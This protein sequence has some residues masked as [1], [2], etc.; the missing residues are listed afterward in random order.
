[1]PEQDGYKEFLPTSPLEGPPL[2]R[3]MGVAWPWQ[4]GAEGPMRRLQ[5][6]KFNPLLM[7]QE[8]AEEIDRLMG[9]M[10]FPEGNGRRP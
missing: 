4:K 6:I 5:N 2:P 9:Q 10:K 1:M 8:M 3:T 7:P